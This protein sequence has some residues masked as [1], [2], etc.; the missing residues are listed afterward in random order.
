MPQQ[1]GLLLVI[2]MH[3][4]IHLIIR[5]HRNSNCRNPSLG[6]VTKARVCKG[7]SQK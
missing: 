2:T 4:N 5:V 1:Y 6:L 3:N 7:A